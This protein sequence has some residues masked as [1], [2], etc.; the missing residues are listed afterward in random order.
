MVLDPFY[1][2]QYGKKCE[3]GPK[4]SRPGDFVTYIVFVCLTLLVGFAIPFILSFVRSCPLKP[5]TLP[6]QPKNWLVTILLSRGRSH[7][8]LLSRHIFRDFGGGGS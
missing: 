8:K 3:T 4:F 6:A 7:F 2:Y 5:S 1:L